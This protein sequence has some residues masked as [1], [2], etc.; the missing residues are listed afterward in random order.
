[1]FMILFLVFGAVCGLKFPGACPKVPSTHFF[2][3]WTEMGEQ[4]LFYTAPFSADTPS[5]LFSEDDSYGLP[6]T[7]KFSFDR[8]VFGDPRE[9]HIELKYLIIG[10]STYESITAQRDRDRVTLNSTELNNDKQPM[11][12]YVSKT[13][14][15][16]VWLD[17][18]IFLIWCYVTLNRERDEAL[19]IFLVPLEYVSPELT[20][21][22]HAAHLKGEFYPELKLTLM[23]S[24]FSCPTDSNGINDTLLN[25]LVTVILFIVVQGYLVANWYFNT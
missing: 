16:R 6:F 19:L 20:N 11:Q 18:P 17:G 2:R 24:S 23:K 21:I 9:V 14:E 22:I 13:E 15:A 10:G 3:N 8:G 12:C 25:V 1:M 4:Q 5:Y 7:H